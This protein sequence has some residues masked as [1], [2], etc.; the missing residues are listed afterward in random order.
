M[1]EFVWKDEFKREVEST[2]L[3]N[4]GVFTTKVLLFST[5]VGA[6]AWYCKIRK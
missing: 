1:A 3:K 5:A 6:T 2:M 4:L